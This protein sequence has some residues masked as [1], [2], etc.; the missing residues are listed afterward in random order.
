MP[1]TP[2]RAPRRLNRSGSSSIRATSRLLT[3]TGL[4]REPLLRG[5][6]RYATSFLGP[7]MLRHLIATI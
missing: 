1:R 2:T 3:T 6:K 5:L 4:L 7:E